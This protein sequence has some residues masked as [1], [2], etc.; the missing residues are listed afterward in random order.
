MHGVA[1]A[2][3]NLVIAAGLL[4]SFHFSMLVMIDTALTLVDVLHPV[5][6]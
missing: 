5:M 1:R 3:T 4:V 2:A 6:K